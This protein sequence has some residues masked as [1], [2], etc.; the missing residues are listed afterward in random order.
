[1][2]D[3]SL[4]VW[5]NNATLQIEG[6]VAYIAWNDKGSLSLVSEEFLEYPSNKVYE[7]VG[8]L[9]DVYGNR[10]IHHVNFTMDV[11]VIVVNLFDIHGEELKSKIYIKQ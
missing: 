7:G 2:Q 8:I 10:T 5:E 1:M 9:V 4:S 6:T 3:N 11:G